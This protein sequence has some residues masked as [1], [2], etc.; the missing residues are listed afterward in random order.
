M[1]RGGDVMGLR[2]CA[3]KGGAPCGGLEL[4]AA[5]ADDCRGGAVAACG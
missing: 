1:G 2:G 4:Q 5:G 3:S